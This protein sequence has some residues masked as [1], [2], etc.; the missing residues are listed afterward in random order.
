MGDFS[1]VLLFSLMPLFMTISVSLLTPVIGAVLSIRNEIM[2]ALALPSLANAGIAIAGFCGIGT[3]QNILLYLFATLFTLVVVSLTISFRCSVHQRELR[4]AGLFI[5]GQILS[6][7]TNAVKGD[8]HS[9]SFLKGEVMAS[10]VTET[11][12]VAAISVGILVLGFVFRTSVF[13][14]CADEEFFRT[15]FM[16][17][18]VFMISVYTIITL[19]V[20][21]GVAMTGTLAVTALMV[22][23]ALLGDSK[24]GGISSY[25]VTVTIIGV[26]GSVSGFLCALALDLPPAIC[27]AASVGI[28]GVSYKVFRMI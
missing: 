17:Y 6:L 15:G 19:F 12:I 5:A 14:W 8:T 27:A 1:E 9:T 28:A 24:R 2:L 21:I 4:L 13:S 7:L 11:V 20:T 22:L 25:M 3:D 18:S 26:L 10:G 23:P 16:R